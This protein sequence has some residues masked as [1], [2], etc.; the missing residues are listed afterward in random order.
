MLSSIR[1]REA[2]K[3][4]DGD[5]YGEAAH[6]ARF[7]TPRYQAIARTD[8]HLRMQKNLPKEESKYLRELGSTGPSLLRHLIRNR[9]A[10]WNLMLA[11][12]VAQQENQLETR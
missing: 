1:Y 5:S 6:Q 11:R 3:T 9:P 7:D 10:M 2:R 4:A 12:A 8:C